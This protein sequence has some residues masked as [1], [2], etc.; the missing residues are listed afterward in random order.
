MN[1]LTKSVLIRRQGTF[2]T[3]KEAVGIV[4]DMPTVG[5]CWV[6]QKPDIMS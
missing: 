5:R 3:K 1:Q 2:L 6:F 4:G